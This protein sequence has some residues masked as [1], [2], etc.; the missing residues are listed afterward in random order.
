MIVSG[1]CTRVP[2]F[3]GVF[4]TSKERAVLVVDMGGST[5]GISLFQLVNPDWLPTACKPSRCN[6][7]IQVKVCDSS[8]LDLPAQEVKQLLQCK[9][10]SGLVNALFY[11]TR[12]TRNF[13]GYA[14][15]RSIIEPF[16]GAY[17]V[18]CQHVTDMGFLW[19]QKRA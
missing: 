10:S 15:E 2:A 9:N 8:N 11:A 13:A 17:Y 14:V 16:A 6:R 12:Y 1:L 4:E 7:S 5:L 18:L 3:L 19:S